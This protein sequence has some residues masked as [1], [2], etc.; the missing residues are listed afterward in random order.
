[1]TRRSRSSR[2]WGTR[3]AASAGQS[4]TPRSG[5][6][7]QSPHS[8]RDVCLP[9]YRP[10]GCRAC[11][12]CTQS[13]SGARRYP[14]KAWDVEVVRP[15][16]WDSEGELRAERAAGI[17]PGAENADA[18]PAVRNRTRTR[19]TRRAGRRFAR[20]AMN[21]AKATAVAIRTSVLGMARNRRTL[22]SLLSR[23]AV[24]QTAP[25]IPRASA[26]FRSGDASCR[27]TRWCSPLC[28]NS[29]QGR[30]N[31]TSLAGCASLFCT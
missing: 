31:T 7:R 24:G 16:G 23:A 2:S 3:R 30:C 5:M 17:G 8:W 26:G 13:G 6:C 25:I 18:R 10:S 28:G 19:R 15:S 9:T 14:A 29:S 12:L 20:A 4:P 1:M 11:H 21:E 27:C 22:R